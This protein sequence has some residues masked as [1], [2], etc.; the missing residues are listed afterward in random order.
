MERF[1]EAIFKQREEINGRM[2]EMFGLLKELIA[3]RTPEKVL[4]REEA[5]HPV[6]KNVNAISLVME[7]VKNIENDEVVDKNVIGLSELNVIE[8]NGVVD[9]KKEVVDGINVEPVRNVREESEEE[10]VEMPR[11]QPVGYYLKHEINEKLIEDL[12][13]NWRFEE[14]TKSGIDLVPPTNAVSRLILEWE[15]RINLH[16]EREMKFNQWRSKMFNDEQSAPMNEEGEVIFDEE[17]L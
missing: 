14:E 2:T 9:I 10:L 7:K 3:S 15:E 6:T 13:G 12:I 17:K 16:Q 4:V 8:P 1:E 11:S 5:R